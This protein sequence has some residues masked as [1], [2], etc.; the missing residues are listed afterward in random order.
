MKPQGPA[1]NDWQ[2]LLNQWLRRNCFC[3]AWRNPGPL[4][5]SLVQFLVQSHYHWFTTHG[6]MWNPRLWPRVCGLG[7]AQ[8]DNGVV[9]CGTPDS[10]GDHHCPR[11]CAHINWECPLILQWPHGTFFLACF[12]CMMCGHENDCWCRQSIFILWLHFL[13]KHFVQQEWLFGP[14]PANLKK[15]NPNL[16]TTSP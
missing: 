5:L 9:A 7:S 4:V 14:E 16:L 1:Q 2:L 3:S 10:I 12:G 8:L 11:V 15:K 13:V 6:I